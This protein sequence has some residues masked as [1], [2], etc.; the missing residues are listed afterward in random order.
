MFACRLLRYCAKTI[1]LSLVIWLLFLAACTAEVV[2]P[3]AQPM[4]MATN[5]AQ[6][7]HTTVEMVATK[8][9]VP[10]A[11][12]TPSPTP[13][14]TLTATPSPTPTVVYNTK[15]IFIQSNSY[16]EVGSDMADF[17]FGRGTSQLIIYADGQTL[18]KSGKRGTVAFAETTLTAVEMCALRDE[19]A[20][21]GYL[22]PHDKEAYYT[23]G[24]P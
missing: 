22:E 5:T 23:D 8:T 21:T 7:V 18:I 17:Y 2:D 13:T 4:P 9:A 24:Y 20:A 10:T 12:A 1:R 14:A 16:G 3:T 19:I 11:T 15:T 6:V